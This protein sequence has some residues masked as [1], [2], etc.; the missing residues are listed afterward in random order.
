MLDYDHVMFDSTGKILGVRKFST[1]TG[2]I[3]ICKTRL[4]V[5]SDQLIMPDEGWPFR[6]N[7]VAS[8][9]SGHLSVCGFDITADL[10]EGPQQALFFY[11]EASI[12]YDQLYNRWNW[13]LRMDA[14][15]ER[16]N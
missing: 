5:G 13:L 4:Y 1:Q 15:M 3:E 10:I 8:I 7:M 9:E 16:G 2:F 14:R 6:E 12:D 11:A